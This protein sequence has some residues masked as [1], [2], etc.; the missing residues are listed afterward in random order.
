MSLKMP[1]EDSQAF[2]LTSTFIPQITP[3]AQQ[4]NV[5]YGFLSANADAGGEAGVKSE[6]YGKLQLLELP[7]ST[8]VPGPG[9]AQAKFDSDTNV[10]RELNLLRQGASSVRNGNL[11]TL[12]VGGGILHVQPVYV[13]STG[14]TSYPT[15]RKV[16]VSFGEQIGFADTLSEALDQLF[17]GDSG[18]VTSDGDGTAGG[19]GGAPAVPGPTTVTNEAE[20]RAAL[21][22]ANQAI[23]DGQAALASG[24]FAAY[25][26]AQTRLNDALQRA[27]NA[28]EAITGATPAPADGATPAPAESPAPS[29]TGGA[30]NNG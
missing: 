12:P 18:A 23:Q 11:L 24:D 14:A 15:L 4:R 9:Q 6:D 30:G 13:Q 21:Q 29:P 22:D 5:L 7:R 3:G 19:G 28:E 8:V 16:L 27:I 17:G 26:E 1:G 2:S 20:L 10:S 25:G